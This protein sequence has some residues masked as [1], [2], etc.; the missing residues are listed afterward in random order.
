MTIARAESGA[1]KYQQD[2]DFLLVELE[3]KA[4]RFFDTKKIN[5]KAVSAEFRSAAAAV[6][7][8]ADHLALCGRLVARL[9]DGHAG[10]VD[11]KVPW[12]DESQGRRFTGPRVHLVEIGDRVFV[13]RSFGAGVPLGVVAGAE[14]L[15]I[16]GVPIRDWLDRT[17][18]RMREKTGYSTD[19]AARYYAC[20]TGLADW[21]GTK[22]EFTFLSNGERKTATVTRSGGP[23]FVPIGP[24]FPPGN[25]QRNGRQSFGRAPSGLG[26]IHLRD[27]PGNLP[28]QLDAAL[29]AIGDVPGLILDMR[30][31]GGGGCDHAAV[32]GR[33][34]P[35][36]KTWQRYSSA[37]PQPFGGPMVVIVDA[38]VRSAGETVAGQFKEDGRALMIGESATAGMSSQKEKLPVPSGLFAVYFSVRSN[39]GRFNSGRGIEGIGV[40]P[41]VIVP[42]EPEDLKNEV[43]TQIRVAAEL[44]ARGFPKGMVAWPG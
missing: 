19:H 28:E 7:T 2:V 29:A 42:A 17:V 37:G 3:K 16:D 18:S 20:H 35:S 39:M 11:R 14:I 21:E 26:Y 10:L 41:H 27:V 24:T 36:G 13:R 15:A 1:T 30:A 9:R 32:F 38:G 22:I 44:I 25:L 31:N 33:F 23:N 6:K 12:P 40:G 34:I 8:D 5:W 43:D 4:G